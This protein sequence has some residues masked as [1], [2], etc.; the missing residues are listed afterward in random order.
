MKEYMY[1]LFV[2]KCAPLSAAVEAATAKY[3]PSLA[4]S[5]ADI[6]SDPMLRDHLTQI[7]L[8]DRM[9]A[10]RMAEFYKVFYAFENY[11]RDFVAN[12]LADLA[13]DDWWE[14][15]VPPVVQEAAKRAREKELAAG[16][17]PRSAEPLEYTT[18]GELSEI[19]KANMASFSGFFP[20]VKGFEGVMARLN[21]LRGPIMHCGVLA[22]D[23]VLRLKLSIRDWFK[24]FETGAPT[25][26][27]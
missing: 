25:S 27:I 19:I 24:L 20:S 4:R 15:Q 16:V 8:E 21:T 12:V 9:Q 17:T 1:E 14:K 22:E 5:A 6:S 7:A 18:F 13:G 2:L 23:E 26:D 3:N 11:I 10:E